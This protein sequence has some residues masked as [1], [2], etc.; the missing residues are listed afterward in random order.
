MTPKGLVS[1]RDEGQVAA[2]ILWPTRKYALAALANA[3]TETKNFMGE[4]SVSEQRSEDQQALGRQRDGYKGGD[5]KM[6]KERR[7]VSN[8]NQTVL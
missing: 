8:P 3:A 6:K 2:H 7:I 1:V 4:G 5:E